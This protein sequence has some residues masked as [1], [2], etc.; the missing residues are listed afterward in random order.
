MILAIPIF[1]RLSIFTFT[2]VIILARANSSPHGLYGHQLSLHGLYGVRTK[3]SVQLWSQAEQLD[4][5]PT[6]V[7]KHAC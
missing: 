2:D 4:N 5:Q 6:V 1:S 3:F 7:Q